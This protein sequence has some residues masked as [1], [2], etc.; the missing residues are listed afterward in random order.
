MTP[1]IAIKLT[2]IAMVFTASTSTCRADVVL[3]FD[4]LPSAQGFNYFAAGNGA[5][6]SENQVFS[7]DGTTLTMNTMGL[8][9]GD[10]GGNW[11]QMNGIV[12]PDQPFTLEWRS[13]V[14]EDQGSATFGHFGFALFVGGTHSVGVGMS[15]QKLVVQFAGGNRITIDHDNTF[16][17]DYKI[18]ADPNTGWALLING[19]PIHQGLS[20]YTTNQNDLFFGDDTGYQ[21]TRTELTYYRFS[22]TAIPEPNSAILLTAAIALISIS[23]RYRKS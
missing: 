18:V 6:F 23:R 14:L 4:S 17:Q 20:F 12:Q 22:Q 5:G 13:R 2:L 15:T 7:T 9:L 19:S 10:A 21:N 16:F 1:R 3:T 11:Y 8:P